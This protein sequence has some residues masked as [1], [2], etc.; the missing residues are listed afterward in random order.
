MASTSPSWSCVVC[1]VINY[2]AGPCE[3]CGSEQEADQSFVEQQ[4]QCMSNFAIHGLE[5]GLDVDAQDQMAIWEAIQASK[6]SSD[7]KMESLDPSIEEATTE[8][9]I[10]TV[11]N[12]D[13]MEISGS[14]DEPLANA[15]VE[16][17]V[18][19]S[20]D[21]RAVGPPAMLPQESFDSWASDESP[22]INQH[23]SEWDEFE[24]HFQVGVG[25]EDGLDQIKDLS[26]QC[27]KCSIFNSNT[28]LQCDQCAEVKNPDIHCDICDVPV[29]FMCYEPHMNSHAAMGHKSPIGIAFAVVNALRTQTSGIPSCVCWDF[30]VNFVRRYIVMVKERGIEIATPEIVYHW[31]PAKNF[32]LIMNGNLKVPDGRKL[33]HQTDEGYYGKGVYTSPNPNYAKCYGHGAKKTIMCLALTGLKYKASYPQMLGKPLQEGYDIHISNDRNEMEWVF[34]SQD[35]LLPA[36]ILLPEQIDSVMPTVEMVKAELVSSMREIMFG[37]DTD[38]NDY[39]SRHGTEIGI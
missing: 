4:K 2:K 34:F 20:P 22:Q 23:S 15:C 29:P 32:D 24:A 9:P 38:L 13:E 17:I 10:V 21:S 33:L 25:E 11:T 39:V 27:V 12:G 19:P 16:D 14:S 36:F 1:T 6:V 18:P 7:V 8:P 35:Q 37:V 3:C 26:W 30:V 5:P 28:F 31:T